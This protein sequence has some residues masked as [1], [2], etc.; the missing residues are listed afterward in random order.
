MHCA[1]VSRTFPDHDYEIGV[2]GSVSRLQNA[3]VHGSSHRHGPSLP[4][5]GK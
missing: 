1:V 5:S 4:P 2:I 3:R